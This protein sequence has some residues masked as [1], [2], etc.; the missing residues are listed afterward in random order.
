MCEALVGALDRTP[1]AIERLYD[2]AHEQRSSA[3]HVDR[4]SHVALAATLI[5]SYK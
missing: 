1:A 3:L 2:R 4:V 5:F